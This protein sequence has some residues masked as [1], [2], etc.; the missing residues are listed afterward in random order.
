[1]ALTNLLVGAEFNVKNQIL[2]LTDLIAA[3]YNTEHGLTLSNIKGM[4]KVTGAISGVVY[5]NAGFD[6]DSYASPDTNGSNLDWVYGGIAL[7]L[8]SN[9]EVRQDVYTIE[10]K[11]ISDGGHVTTF[12][13]SKVYTHA[14]NR[15]T[16]IVTGNATIPKSYATITDNTVYNVLVNSVYYAPANLDSRLITVNWPVESGQPDSITANVSM[17]LGP[18]IWTGE[19]LISLNTP[20]VYTLPSAAGLTVTVVDTISGTSTMSDE[21]NDCASTVEVC[22]VSLSAQYEQAKL[23]NLPEAQTLKKNLD[24]IGMYYDMYNMA[25][26]TSKDTTYSCEIL[27]ALV[28][29]NGCEPQVETFTSREIIPLTG[30][31]SNKQ[32]F[33]VTDVAGQTVFD[34]EFVLNVNS[35]VLIDGIAIINN[36]IEVA[37][38]GTTTLT[39]VATV[40]QGQ[41]VIIFENI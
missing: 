33:I 41:T 11:I 29:Q 38:F 27:R 37:S 2:E 14:Y 7:P 31:G 8:D 18:N 3:D 6:A 5:E 4:F 12:T 36:Q 23:Y 1:M 20:V 35:L 13:F 21:V 32:E 16:A 22:M 39:T 40:T 9:N 25:I 10:Y 19:Y 26:L 15:P 30:V 24:D 34:L 28:I 17:V